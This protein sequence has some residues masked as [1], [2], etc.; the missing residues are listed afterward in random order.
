MIPPKEVPTDQLL[1]A[2]A[3]ATAAAL[4]Q[5]D[6]AWTVRGMAWHGLAWMMNGMDDEWHG[7]W[8]TLRLRLRLR[9]L[10]RST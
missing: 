5:S 2:A 1:V 7:P 8:G 9:L 10:Y 3:S 4:L 6:Q